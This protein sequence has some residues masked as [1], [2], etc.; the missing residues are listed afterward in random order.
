MTQCTQSCQHAGQVPHAGA[1]SAC[2]VQSHGRVR[3]V[4]ERR[5]HQAR[6][7]A[8]GAD[9][10][11]RTHPGS[12]EILE[13][14]DEV[15]RADQLTGQRVAHRVGVIGV[16]FRRA[17]G[18]DGSRPAGNRNIVERLPEACSGVD[19]QRAVEPRGDL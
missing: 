13:L 10:D 4:A 8:A 7:D 14:G 5:P 18:V 15:D 17:V 2:G 11:E 1:P 3:P 16:G 9:L 19:H 6:Q 12:M